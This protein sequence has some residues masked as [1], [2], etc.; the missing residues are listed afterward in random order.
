MGSPHGPASTLEPSFDCVIVYVKDV[1]KSVEFYERAFGLTERREEG[2]R[3]TMWAEMETGETT[4]AF[5]A[6]TNALGYEQRDVRLAGG[7]EPPHDQ[8]DTPPNVVISLMYSDVHA[9]YRH[10]VAN[11]ALGMAPPENKPWG[12]TAGYVKDI[13]GILVQ[14]ASPVRGRT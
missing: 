13:D 1:D 11:G 10:A 14:L 12:M 9:A 4:L 3:K 5:T 2:R 6:I 7:I 8:S